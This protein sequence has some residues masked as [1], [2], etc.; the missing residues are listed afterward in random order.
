MKFSWDGWQY[1][2][3]VTL[4]VVSGQVLR[5]GNDAQ[6][7]IRPTWAR[8]MIDASML[9]AFG[10]VGG[11]LAYQ[12]DWPVWGIMMGGVLAGWLGF[13]VPKLLGEMA[14]LWIKSKVGS[15][16]KKE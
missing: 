5:W 12:N 10:G 3:I 15:G 16:E 13:A 14:L 4:A 9:P 1:Y 7:G 2:V 6:R 11:A 8:T